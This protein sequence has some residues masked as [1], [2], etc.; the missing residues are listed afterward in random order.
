VAEVR[1][2]ALAICLLLFAAPAAAQEAPTLES[3]LARFA[4]LPGLEARFVEEKRIA[5]LAVPVRSEGRIYFAPPGRLLRRVTSP[6]AS[7]ALID[8]GR[9]RMRQ[10]ERTEELSIDENPVLRGFIDSFRAV[11]A[12]DRAAL[13]RFYRAEVSAR[14]EE[15]AG[16]WELRL[17]PRNGP[18]ARFLREIRMRGTDATLRE[19]RMVEVNGDETRTEFHDV[20]TRRR[21]EAAEARRLFRIEE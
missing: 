21:Y 9:L 2:S 15:G 20:N 5:L 8:E 11:L 10:G 16:G 6:E 7:S 14:P 19:M 4:G 18:L 12:G 1:R 17:R 3:L 13:E